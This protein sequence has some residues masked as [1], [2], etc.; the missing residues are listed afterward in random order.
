MSFQPPVTSPSPSILVREGSTSRSNTPVDALTIDS[1]PRKKTIGKKKPLG[2]RVATR[3][4]SSESSESVDSVSWP[5]VQYRYE[6]YRKAG[7]T[8]EPERSRPADP[9][10]L[11]ALEATTEA[12]YKSD[13]EALEY[14]EATNRRTAAIL[15]HVNRTRSQLRSFDDVMERIG[16]FLG[17]RQNTGDRWAGQRSFDDD[18]LWEKSVDNMTV[19]GSPY[20][21]FISIF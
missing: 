8:P 15:E 5:G 16:L 14:I 6:P 18:S 3:T 21:G 4:E 11:E 10:D 1:S 12:I 7:P 20:V 13:R 19:F 17:Q 9:R 2:K